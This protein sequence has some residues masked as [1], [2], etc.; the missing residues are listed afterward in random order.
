[1][2]VIITIIMVVRVINLIAVII[3]GGNILAEL[4]WAWPC[5]KNFT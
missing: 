5:T 3:T 1:M 2:I 4:L